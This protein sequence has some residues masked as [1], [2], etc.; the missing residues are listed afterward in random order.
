MFNALDRAQ[1]YVH[2]TNIDFRI[3]YVSE[4]KFI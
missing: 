3:I 1:K 4:Y 2:R